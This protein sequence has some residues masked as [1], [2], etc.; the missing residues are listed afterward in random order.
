MTF[1]AEQNLDAESHENTDE[2]EQLKSI[3]V[4]LEYE[5]HERKKAEAR[6]AEEEGRNRKL[7]VWI[8]ELIVC[9]NLESSIELSMRQ[10]KL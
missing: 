9:Y 6:L 1:R 10:Q 7:K 2:S 8:R 5:R 4:E 3:Q